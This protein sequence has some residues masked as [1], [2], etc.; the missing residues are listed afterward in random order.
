MIANRNPFITFD[1]YFLID[2]ALFFLW[3]KGTYM[4]FKTTKNTARLSAILVLSLSTLIGCDNSAAPL[5]EED[6]QTVS[7]QQSPENEKLKAAWSQLVNEYQNRMLFVPELLAVVKEPYDEEQAAFAQ[8]KEARAEIGSLHASSE[9]LNDPQKMNEYLTAQAELDAAIS[10]LIDVS[11]RYPELTSDVSFQ[12]LIAQMQREA[13]MITIARNQYAQEGGS[14]DTVLNRYQRLQDLAA[15][16]P[17]LIQPYTFDGEDIF[18]Q[19]DVAK[20][21]IDT[22]SMTASMT[23]EGMTAD[24][25]ATEGTAK[26]MAS[27]P[28]AVDR[29]LA[30]QTQMDVALQRLMTTAEHYTELKADADFKALQSQLEQSTNRLSIARDNYTQAAQKI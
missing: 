12:D 23:A 14:Y 28:Q 21:N 19:V 8:L 11:N 4:T 18:N 16:L 7:D 13:N 29:Y 5:A 20:K 3:S 30:A 2:A 6:T 15:H 9:Q 26:D 1:Y 24:A 22:I 10:Q 17:K 25:I 27:D